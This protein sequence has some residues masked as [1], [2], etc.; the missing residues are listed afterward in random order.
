MLSCCIEYIKTRAGNAWQCN[1]TEVV[2]GR[3]FKSYLDHGAPLWID[4]CSFNEH[5]Q[6]FPKADCCSG[7]SVPSAFSCSS[8]ADT[9]LPFLHSV[10]HELKQWEITTRRQADMGWICVSRRSI[11]KG[12]SHGVVV[13]CCG[14]LGDEPNRRFLHHWRL[15]V[16][17]HLSLYFLTLD[18]STVSKMHSCHKAL[19]SS[20]VQPH[21]AS[22]S[23]FEFQKKKM[24]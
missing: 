17:D 10:N 9:H 19:H 2:G 7:D 23:K 13:R 11:C 8:S 6:F 16:P 15:C 5:E 21:G 4:Q 18:V 24:N 12:F 3:T 20:R 14:L 22:R 1:D